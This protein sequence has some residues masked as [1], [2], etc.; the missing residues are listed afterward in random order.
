MIDADSSSKIAGVIRDMG[1]EIEVIAPR[2]EKVPAR[3]PVFIVD[4]RIVRKE[5]RDGFQAGV[6]WQKTRREIAEGQEADDTIDDAKLGKI[7]FL[8]HDMGRKIIASYIESSQAVAER[9][10]AYSILG[11]N[12][13]RGFNRKQHRTPTA[14]L[15]VI[16][17]LETPVQDPDLRN[18][19]TEMLDTALII[20]TA[21]Q[22]TLGPAQTTISD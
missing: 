8:G 15:A 3:H 13:L 12:G 2:L 14:P 21:K 10:A 1:P 4:P 6:D 17:Q 7:V 18:E 11:A 19:I 20:H 5:F 9:K 22:I 16:A